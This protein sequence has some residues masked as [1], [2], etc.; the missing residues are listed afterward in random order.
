MGVG[1]EK[2]T[3]TINKAKTENSIL[4]RQSVIDREEILC[5]DVGETYS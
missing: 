5:A 4:M 3:N 1:C 2:K